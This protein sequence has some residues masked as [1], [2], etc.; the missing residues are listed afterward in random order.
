VQHVSLSRDARLLAASGVAKGVVWS[1]E[2]HSQ[3]REF[4]ALQ[5]QLV[6]MNLAVAF[7][8]TEDRFATG[9]PQGVIHIW[10]TNSWEE[11]LRLYNGQTPIGRLNFSPD[12]RRLA[13]GL[14][15][16]GSA[17]GGLRVWDSGAADQMR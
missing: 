10:D 1:V 6:W 8:P 11:V 12:G 14:F 17:E 15:L 16:Y 13:A 3:V 7:S 4:A 9:D 2:D 5:G